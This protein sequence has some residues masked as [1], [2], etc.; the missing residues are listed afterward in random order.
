MFTLEAPYPLL[1]TTTLL[2][3][4]KFSDAEALVASVTRKTAID[5]TRYTYVKRKDGRRKLRWTFRLTRNKS[6]ELRAFITSYFAC[7]LRVTDHRNRVWV[8][9]FDGQ[10][11][12]VRRGGARRPA[13]SP[14]ASRRDDCHQSRFRGGGAMRSISANGLAKL[15]TQL[16]TEPIAIVE[17][18][19]VPGQTSAYADRTVASIPGKIVELSELD[20]VTSVSGHSTNQQVTATLD[21]VDGTI[22][23][24]LDSHDVH[25]RPAR[26]YQYFDGLDLADRFKLFSGFISTPVVWS[27]RD[28]TVRVT[29]L[30]QLEITEVD[31]SVEDSMPGP[32]PAPLLGKNFPMIFGT[33]ENVP[34]V[35][36]QAPAVGALLQPVGVLAGEELYLKFPFGDRMDFDISVAKAQYQIQ[37]LQQAAAICGDAATAA[38]NAGQSAA[39]AQYQQAQN[40]YQTQATGLQQQLIDKITQQTINDNCTIARRQHQ[41]NEAQLA[42]LRAESRPDSRRRILSPRPRHRGDRRR[43]LHRRDGGKRIPHRRAIERL[44]HETGG[45]GLQFQDRRDRSPE[46]QLRSLHRQS[47]RPAVLA[48]DRRQD[49]GADDPT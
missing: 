39:A 45:R 11:L 7:Q 36:Y 23:A 9:N 32:V 48:V 33:V 13:D 29:I 22:K 1:Q 43:L 2:P 27:E 31:F 47:V 35:Q 3:D 18:D 40:S 17:I 37:Y 30:S 42:G 20:D 5:G 41:I 6:L 34:T 46:S 8:G 19:W 25:K 10:S 16:G 44:S 21:D 28:R 38:A 12:R 24:V 4:P 49:S 14:A 15:R 26:V